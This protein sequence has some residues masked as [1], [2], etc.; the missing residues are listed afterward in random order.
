MDKFANIEALVAVVESGSFSRAAERLDLTKSVVS[1]RVSQL[2]ATLGVQLLQRT[3]RSQSLTAPGRDFYERALRI[4]ADLDDAEQAIIDD[5][6]A[7]RGMLKIAAP[8][9]FGIKHLSTALSDFMHAHPGVELD[10]DLNDREVNL[11][12]EGF[13]MTVRIGELRDSTLLARKLGTVRFVT[14]ASKQYLAQ[15]G[16]PRHPEELERHIGLHY[17]NVTLKQAWQFI[18]VDGQ[19]IVSIPGIRMRANNGDALN[20]AAIAG[21]GIINT[22]TFIAAEHI[23]DGHLQTILDD[24]QR[25]KT[26]IYAVYPPGRLVPRRVHA[27]ADFLAARFGEQP[28]WDGMLGITA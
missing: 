8:L 1:R 10:L 20:A 28:Y 26:G 23:V 27:F 5:T 17:A 25:P 4:L 7:L 11:V 2:E 3:T 18:G 12:E 24:Y 16:S 9:S 21:L 6:S 14:C 15:H 13:D 19:T 22:P